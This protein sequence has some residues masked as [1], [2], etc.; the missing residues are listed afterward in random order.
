MSDFQVVS[1][2]RVN[3]EDDGIIHGAHMSRRT[4]PKTEEDHNTRPQKHAACFDAVLLNSSAESIAQ[5]ATVPILKPSLISRDIQKGTQESDHQPMTI[6]ARQTD[7]ENT[8]LLSPPH[9]DDDDDDDDD[10]NDNSQTARRQSLR[11]RIARCL[12]SKRGDYCVLALVSLNIASIIAA[13][14]VRL[15]ACEGRIPPKPSV[16]A[17]HALDIAGLVFRCLFAVELSVRVGVFGCA[18]FRSWFNCLDAVVIVLGV[19]IDVLLE[20]V[21]GEI[22]SFVVVLRLLRVFRIIEGVSNGAE[23]RMMGMREQIDF[24][25]RENTSLREDVRQLRAD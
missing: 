18:Y 16:R 14:I 23:E 9:D 11:R 3:G 5:I 21:M 1:K 7:E 19:A 8:P 25:F 15:F 12:A 2:L 13:L 17:E 20:G 4:P 6:M 10:V 24:L 22:A